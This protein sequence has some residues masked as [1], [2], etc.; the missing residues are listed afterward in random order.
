MGFLSVSASG[1]LKNKSCVS[2]Y[3]PIAADVVG[4][5][6][7]VCD[8]LNHR[9]VGY[10]SLVSSS[11]SATRVIGQPNFVSGDA[12]VAS[13]RLNTPSGVSSDGMRFFVSD[14]GSSRVVVLESVPQIAGPNFDAILGQSSSSGSQ[15]NRGQSTPTETTL[16]DPAGCYF[17]GR[18]LYVV[19]R[20]NSRIVRFR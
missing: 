6:L 15:A 1:G 19:D 9:V 17:D 8:S 4:G 20:G 7:W 16:S 13:N 2:K 3:T 14:A 5:I 18:S 12:G 10:S 11:I